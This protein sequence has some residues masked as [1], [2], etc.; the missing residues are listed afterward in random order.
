V[1]KSLRCDKKTKHVLASIGGTPGRFPL[2]LCESCAPW[3]LTYI[4][5]FIQIRSGLGRYNR[6]PAP[7]DLQPAGL[8]SQ[9]AFRSIGWSVDCIG[10]S[11]AAFS[12]GVR[13]ALRW[14]GIGGNGASI[15]GFLS[16][17][18]SAWRSAIVHV[19]FSVVFFS[20][21]KWWI[22]LNIYCD[23]NRLRWTY[24]VVTMLSV[25]LS[26]GP[27]VCNIHTRTDGQTDR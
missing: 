1:A 11:Q 13:A 18:F 4:P 20:T 21:R 19:N 26:V 17:G 23:K 15:P 27:C 6:K 24:C 2:F 3:P 9:A 14:R 7:R 8:Q 10:L 16:C 22:K 25:R 12:Q 5:G